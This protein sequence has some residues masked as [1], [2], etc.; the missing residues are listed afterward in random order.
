VKRTPSAALAAALITLA[1]PAISHAA[2]GKTVYM[3]TPP[4]SQKALGK[5]NAD[6]NAFFPSSITVHV[7]QKVSFVPSGF[8]NVEFPA[9]GAKPTPLLSPQGPISGA[10]D[11]AGAAYWFN[12]Q[13]NLGF[14]PTLF[15]GLYGK[16]VKYTG[17]KT[18]NTGL[19]LADK[20]K[21]VKISFTKPGT[22]TYFCDVH[23]GMKGTVK[24]VADSKPV[25]SVKADAKRVAAQAKAAIAT[26]KLVVKKQ[27]PANTVLI[28][29]AGKGGVEAFSFFPSALT[30]P[31][32][33]TV[34]FSMDTL[35][36][37]VHTATTGPGDPEQPATFLGKLEAST[38][39]PTFDPQVIYPSDPPPAGPAS[40]TPASHG[41]GFWNSGGLDENPATP[42][43]PPANQVKFDAP[44]TYTFYCMIHP[45]MKGTVTVQ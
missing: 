43:V 19:P 34:T 42:F 23:V 44:G 7:G 28:G 2:T 15:Q 13:Q 11:A 22:Y 37:E 16:S 14:S 21:P 3:G 20:P 39:S 31:V 18:V 26:A 30:V 6:V 32:G 5:Y 27:P 35:S 40:L 36:R 45:F 9:K 38:E 41:N 29:A 12:G 24:V 1:V 8:H 4:T 25:P 10:L 33:T 17:A